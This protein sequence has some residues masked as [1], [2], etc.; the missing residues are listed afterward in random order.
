M[1]CSE[2]TNLRNLQC[3]TSSDRVLR[4]RDILVL[5]HLEV[6]FIPLPSVIAAQTKS[7]NYPPTENQTQQGA[8]RE[9]L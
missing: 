3:R 6:W 7:V 8:V 1:L 4:R 2:L 5:K 9:S